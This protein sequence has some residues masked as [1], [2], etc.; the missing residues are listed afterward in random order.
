MSF[1]GKTQLLFLLYTGPYFNAKQV[2]FR[3]R[4]TLLPFKHD[5]DTQVFLVIFGTF[6]IS[7]LTKDYM[8]Q[9]Y[10]TMVENGP[11]VQCFL[12]IASTTH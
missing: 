7:I 6:L 12:T 5:H 4:T 11:T 10:A 2:F 1:Y 8:L 3:S 9:A